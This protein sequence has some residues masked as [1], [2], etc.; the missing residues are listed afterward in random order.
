MPEYPSGMPMLKITPVL[1]Q[2]KN[3]HQ[4]TL[5]KCRGARAAPHHVHI[6]TAQAR[7]ACSALIQTTTACAAPVTDGRVLTLRSFRGD[8][9]QCPCYH[10]PPRCRPP[11]STSNLPMGRLCPFGGA[12]DCAMQILRIPSATPCIR[13]NLIKP[14]A[15]AQ[16]FIVS[17][18]L[19]FFPTSQ[20]PTKKATPQRIFPQHRRAS[21]IE[22]ARHRQFYDDDDHARPQTKVRRQFS[23]V[24]QR[25]QQ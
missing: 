13:Q 22:T 7:L 10:S 23:W 5:K 19:S 12:R 1:H 6:D 14:P 3:H 17:P 15:R 18:L 2:S 24:Q 16:T 20:D 11:N 4:H 21:G 25:Q 9:F 8:P